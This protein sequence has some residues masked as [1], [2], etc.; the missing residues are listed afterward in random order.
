[1]QVDLFVPCL[2]IRFILIQHS[3]LLSFSGS[4]NY[5]KLQSGANLLRATVV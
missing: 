1:M 4:R 2:S 5:S 3:T